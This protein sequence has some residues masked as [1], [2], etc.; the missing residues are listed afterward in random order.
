MIKI[1]RYSSYGIA[2]DG[3]GE[4]SFDNGYARNIVIFGVN[5]SSSYHADNHKKVKEILLVLMGAL[6]HQKKKV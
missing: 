6:V 3:N 1:R 2:F 4:W 5:N